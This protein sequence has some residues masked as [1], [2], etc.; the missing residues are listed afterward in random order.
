MQRVILGL[1]LIAMSSVAQLPRDA[2]KLPA[3]QPTGG[4]S[5]NDA[6]AARRSVR[7]FAS[8]PLTWG[9]IGQLLWAAQGVTHDDGKRTAPSAGATYPLELY[10]ATAAGLY[11]YLPAR[12]E[13]VRVAV[14]DVRPDI[15][16]AAGAQAAVDAPALFVFAAA[17]ARTAGR[18]GD[19]AMRYVYI[20][21]GHAAQNLLLEAAAL[22]LAAVPVGSFTDRDMHRALGLPADQ[23]VVYV[24]PVGRGR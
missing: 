23:V 10:V 4:V 17:P 21:T 18:Y 14:Q 3:P 15:R 5:L 24:V 6:L 16:R 9:Q 2:V 11:H 8:G 7:E 19:R 1:A 12:H 20:E 22:G 13:V